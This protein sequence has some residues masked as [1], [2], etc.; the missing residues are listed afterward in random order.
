MKLKKIRSFNIADE[1]LELLHEYMWDN[2]IL[3]RSEGLEKLLHEFQS[4]KKENKVQKRIIEIKENHIE[5]MKGELLKYLEKP[6]K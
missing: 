5:H 1:D 6:E 4:L 3:T 2:K